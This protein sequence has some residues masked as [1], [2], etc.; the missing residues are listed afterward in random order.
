MR[1]AFIIFL[2]VLRGFAATTSVDV[3]LDME[4]GSDNSTVTAGLLNSAT[5]GSGGAWGTFVFPDS[6]AAFLSTMKVTTDFEPLL[7]TP[8]TV[9]TDAYPDRGTSRGYSFSNLSNRKFARYTF[10]VTH[11]KVSMGCFV[12]IGNFDGSTSGSY[13]LI[14]MEGD[15]EFAVLNF[16]DFPGS[17]FVFQIHTQAGVNDAFP[18]TPNTTYWMTLLWDQ[19]NRRASMKV[20]DAMTW[21]LVGNSS[22]ALEPNK[23]CQTV[24]FGRYDGHAATTSALH[25]YDDLMIDYSAADFPILPA[26]IGPS[27]VI[28][29]A[30]NL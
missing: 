28:N 26:R 9:G 15:G 21:Q 18:V 24:C 16:Q 1:V 25:Y 10:D 7:G 13:D 4:S 8:V 17:D 6:P 22:I 29:Y 3:Y 11:P 27:G 19:P 5:H 12:R 30:V 14:A 2:C 20:Y 23:E